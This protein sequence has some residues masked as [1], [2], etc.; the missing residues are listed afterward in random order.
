MT[1][2]G[3][4]CTMRCVAI[5]FLYGLLAVT[6]GAVGSI[7]ITA[8]RVGAVPMPSSP[9]IHRA[10][11]EEIARVPGARRVVEV[12]SGW[13]GLAVRIARSQPGMRVVGVEA[14]AVPW[15]VSRVRRA[16]PGAP[17]NLEFRRA[18]FRSTRI[19]AHT[20]YVCYLS[21]SAM[22]SVRDVFEDGAREGVVVISALFAV[23]E[24]QSIRTRTARDV[25]TTRI[26]VY[27]PRTD[28]DRG[29]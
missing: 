19:E 25:H 12:G 28:P 21:P 7:F 11:V 23:R 3:P 16:I 2:R 4:A 8:H 5:W 15:L 22:R 1:N 17:E 6:I 29:G 9:Q 26:F 18:D 14:S 24:W 10:V 20:V 13:G 27:E